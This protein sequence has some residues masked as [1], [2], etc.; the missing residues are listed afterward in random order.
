MGSV[1]IAAL[2]LG[3]ISCPIIAFVIVDLP[4]DRLFFCLMLKKVK[5]I[6]HQAFIIVRCAIATLVSNLVV[7][8]H[9]H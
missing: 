9:S 6:A 7:K 5:A 4:G 8:Y 1:V 3:K 2:R